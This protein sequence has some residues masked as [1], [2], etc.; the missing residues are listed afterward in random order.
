MSPMGVSGTPD[1]IG[2][3]PSV[4]TMAGLALVVGLLYYLSKK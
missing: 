3:T 4:N 2:S 1:G